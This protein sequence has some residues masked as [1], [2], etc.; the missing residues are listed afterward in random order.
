MSL[1]A[2]QGA[3]LIL[4]HDTGVKLLITAGLRIVQWL[5]PDKELVARWESSSYIQQAAKAQLNEAEYSALL[6]APLLFLA[7]SS[8]TKNEGNL[9]ATLAV[10][11]QVGYFWMRVLTG[12]PTI[13]T[14]GSA[15]IRY[16][17]L[18]LICA[19][20][21]SVAFGKNKASY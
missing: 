6:I 3:S 18:G 8:N 5:H 16:M 11:G 10:L 1:S 15:A 17:G 9:G 14:A 4:I 7:S 19:E 13:P 12:Y 20:I 21:W 2:L